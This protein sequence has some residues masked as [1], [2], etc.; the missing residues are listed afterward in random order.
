MVARQKIRESAVAVAHGRVLV[1]V[2]LDAGFAGAPF[3]VWD[4]GHDVW[5]VFAAAPPGGF[6]W[7]K[8]VS[9]DA[10]R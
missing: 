7:M 1:S 3:V 8:N 4:V 9:R 10:K 6:V 5:D 2:F